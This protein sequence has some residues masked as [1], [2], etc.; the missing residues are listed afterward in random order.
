MNTNITAFILTIVALVLLM[1]S[2]SSLENNH[3]TTS[4][5][6]SVV[7]IAS[8]VKAVKIWDYLQKENN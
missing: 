6:L 7:G 4:F 1:A 3:F 5:V 8:A 2:A